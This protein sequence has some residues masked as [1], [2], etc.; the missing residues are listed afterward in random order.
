MKYLKQSQFHEKFEDE[1][2]LIDNPA[3]VLKK[4]GNNRAIRYGVEI[5]LRAIGEDPNREGLMETPERVARMYLNE[6]F[7]NVNKTKENI[8]AEFSKTFTD[9]DEDD[10]ITVEKFGDMVIVKD[11]PFYSMCE[12]HLVPF[13]G[14]AHVGYIPRNKVI[15]LSKIARLVDAIAKRP[16][17]QERITKDVAECMEQML[18]PIGVIVVVEAE[19]LCMAMRGVRKPGAKTVT[20]A[21]RGAFKED[22]TTRNEF[23]SLINLK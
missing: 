23:L 19:H 9:N 2:T 10:D 22:S 8:V 4:L 16:Q 6:V 20:S 15:G 7:S 12:H 11:I 1:A 17:L 3:E 21:A 5:I 18:D 13:Y 14:K